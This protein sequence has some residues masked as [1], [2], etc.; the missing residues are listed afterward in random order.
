MKDVKG[1]LVPKKN[2][3]AVWQG[4]SIAHECAEDRPDS[5]VIGYLSPPV[6]DISR[7]DQ[8]L[9]SVAH[10]MS[11]VDVEGCVLSDADCDRIW[12]IEQA[13]VSAGL[14]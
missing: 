5:S 4:L 13:Y 11:G 2:G 3:T 14:Y 12:D 8:F 10:L 7:G 9:G 6:L 1:H